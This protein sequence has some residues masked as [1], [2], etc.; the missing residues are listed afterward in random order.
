MTTGGTEQRKLAAIMFTDMV[1]YSALAQ[2]DEK[3]ALELLDEQQKLIRPNLPQ[4]GGREVKTTGD[5]FLVEFPS[6]LAAC[7]CAIQIQETLAQ[8]NAAV[9]A[10]N[11]IHVRIGFHLGDVVCRAADVYGDGVN[12]AARIEP[13]AEPGGVCVTRA[14]WEQVH[15]KL[16]QPL[17]RIG[18][19]ELKNIQTPMEL[20]RIV[21]SGE[22]GAKAEGG[23]TKAESTASVRTPSAWRSAWVAAI[24]LVAVAAAS[25]LLHQSGRTAK[26]AGHITSLAVKPLDDFSGDTNNAYLSDGMTE[27]LCMALGNISVLRVPGRSSVMK[28][29]G[30][31]K[32]IQE[33]AKDLNVEAIVEGS[34]QRTTT[35]MLLT[36]QLIEAATDRHLWATNYKRDLSD[37]FVVQSEVARAIAKEVQARLTPEDQA[38]LARTRTVNPAAHEAYLRGRYVFWH[39]TT[40]N[41]EKARTYFEEA[42]Q[43]D[44][45][46]ALAYSGLADYYIGLQFP[47]GNFPPQEVM[48]KTKAAAQKALELDDQLSEAHTSLAWVVMSY[49]YDWAG[50]GNE[51]QRALELNPKNWQAHFWQG[52]YLAALGKVEAAVAAF[53]HSEELDPLY[54]IGFAALAYYWGGQYDRAI[55]EQERVRK[56]KPED[57]F[58]QGFFGM[59]YVQQGRFP[60]ALKALERQVAFPGGDSPFTQSV[61]GHAYASAGQNEK[62]R[63]I[64]SELLARKDQ[65]AE[66]I[67]LVY[68][69]LNDQDK[70]FAWLDRAFAQRSLGYA[71]KVEPRWKNLR[72]D[73]RFAEMLRKMNY[74]P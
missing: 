61:L 15:N 55:V 43:L 2:R 25:W 26:A 51:F 71:F 4:F 66:A 13:L 21:L 16:A 36:V 42:I 17:E 68:A 50:A 44:P 74:P 58:V 38:R 5:G 9:P 14:V 6:A 28:Y 64:L 11:R 54:P 19:K 23:R 32:S 49:D 47:P 10:E 60:E 30:G 7:E 39:L 8:H 31:Q 37:F 57:V 48:P 72:A 12:I 3:L 33:M 22:K 63:K 24:I 40:D 27:A 46:M 35:N 45:Q 62:A 52:F 73:P 29:K 1:G 56:K 41:L 18:A 20:F 53:K 34:V 70:A 67:A 69:G 65:S 59:I